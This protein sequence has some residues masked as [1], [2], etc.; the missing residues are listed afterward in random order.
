MNKSLYD[1]SWQVNEKQYRDYN[2]LSHSILVKFD[3]EGFYNL[4]T[5]FDKIESS[6]LTFGSCVDSL[7]TGGQEEFNNKFIVCENFL[8]EDT[9]YYTKIIHNEFSNNYDKFISIPV[10]QVS[11]LLKQN[12]FWTADKWS[13]DSRYKAFLKKGDIE[14]YYQIL[15]QSKDK[16]VIDRDT[17]QD[18]MK[19][20]VSLKTSESTRFYFAKNEAGS[21]IKRYYQ[22]KFKNKFNGVEYKSMLDLVLVDYDN[23][24][25][26]PVDLK[27]SSTPEA[28][29]YKSFVKYNYSDQARLYYRN[30][31]KACEEDEYFKDFR[32]ENF[33]FIVVNRRTLMP[34]T[35]RYKD[36]SAFGELRYGKDNNIIFKDPFDIGDELNYYLTHSECKVPIGIKTDRTNDLLSYLEIM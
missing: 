14:R 34:L 16:I 13:D 26:Y 7:I 35:W 23:K 20:V 33:T 31:A 15:T 30:L 11:R 4:N 17:Y 25:I 29:F 5:L 24:I 32:I 12:G 9:M 27:T 10:I 2:C 22:L 6:S 28:E 21:N 1:I 3:K 8:D 18:A 19:C 36:M